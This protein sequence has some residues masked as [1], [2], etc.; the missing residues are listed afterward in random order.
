MVWNEPEN[1][2]ALRGWLVTFSHPQGLGVLLP[3]FWMVSSS[4]K[5]GLSLRATHPVDSQVLQ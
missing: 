4:L 5:T 1:A 3:Y 2:A